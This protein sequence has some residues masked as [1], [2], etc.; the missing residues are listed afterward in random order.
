[1]HDVPITRGYPFRTRVTA[2]IFALAFAVLLIQP[3]TAVAINV[4]KYTLDG[5][6]F[7]DGGTGSGFVLVDFDNLNPMTAVAD[8]SISITDALLPGQPFLLNS[9]TS[10][11]SVLPSGNNDGFGVV[12]VWQTNITGFH[13]TLQF[14]F[15]LSLISYPYPTGSLDL[16][17]LAQLGHYTDW[18]Y[19]YNAEGALVGSTALVSGRFN[20][21]GTVPEPSSMLLCFFG[22]IAVAGLRGKFK[23]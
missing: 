7:V 9:S 5:L 4:Q 23:K 21:P 14:F 17:A 22:F 15:P 3:G 6:Q 10:S 12:N 16:V 2:V 20:P 11:T 18:L 19:V 1:M 13:A 8:H